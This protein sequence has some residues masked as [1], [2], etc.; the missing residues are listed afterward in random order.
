MRASLNLFAQTPI[1]ARRAYRWSL[2]L[3]EELYAEREA[4]GSYGAP[5]AV[6]ASRAISTALAGN[7]H[8]LPENNMSAPS[9]TYPRVS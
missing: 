9:T 4:T 1:R 7:P 6:P 2:T 8:E 3:A 5:L